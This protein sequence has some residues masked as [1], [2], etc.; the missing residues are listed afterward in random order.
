MGKQ[1][2]AVMNYFS[3]EE[4]STQYLLESVTTLLQY[5]HQRRC[6]VSSSCCCLSMPIAYAQKDFDGSADHPLIDRYAGSFIHSYASN[7]YE[8]YPIMLDYYAEKRE[9]I[10]GEFTSIIYHAPAGRSQ[11]EVHRNYE[12]ALEHSSVGENRKRPE[13]TDKNQVKTR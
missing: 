2:T 8:E 3:R 7:N 12:K 11:L 9:S 1:E 13:K 4:C 10:E 5:S 6:G